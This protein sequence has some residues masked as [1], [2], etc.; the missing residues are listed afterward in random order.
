MSRSRSQGARVGTDREDG[1]DS[2]SVEAEKGGCA[3]QTELRVTTEDRE[4]REVDR[5]ESLSIRARTRSR[6]SITL[7]ILT[8]GSVIETSHSRLRFADITAR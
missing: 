6:A 8:R 7:L 3:M 1:V 2:L 5:A 4:H